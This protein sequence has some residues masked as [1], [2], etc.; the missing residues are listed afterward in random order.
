MT[1]IILLN[2]NGFQDTIECLESLFACTKQD[3]VWAVVDNGS[4][5]E[6][7]Q[8]ITDYLNRRGKD[9]SVVKE[10]E[11]PSFSL[12]AGQGV[13][14]AL[15]ENYGFA[16]GNNM[17][18]ALVERLSDNDG[19]DKP[20]HYLLL[21]NDTLV[22][23]D[24]LEKLET[25]SL[26]NPQY[27]AL[28]PQIRRA[29]N[30]NIIWNCGGKLVF[31]LR[32]YRYENKP[33]SAI[34]E[35]HCMPISLITGCALFV[36]RELIGFPDAW[37]QKKS[38]RYAA[39]PHSQTEATDVLSNRFFFGEEDFDFSLRLQDKKQKMACVLDSVIYH[40]AG[41]SRKQFLPAGH[42]YMH[43]LNRF[44]DVRQHWHPFKFFIWKLIYMP[45]ISLALLLRDKVS[46]REIFRYQKNLWKE[47]A[48]LDGMDKALFLRWIF[49]K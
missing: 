24:F 9:F 16:K 11:N 40:K 38:K 18:I 33:Y 39:R 19:A 26:K 15:G 44:V 8:A 36:K 32:I 2:W 1:A 46:I 25:F 41:E 4:E 6:S 5:N 27:V 30:K 34:K 43:H 21:N 48:E 42:L 12:K 22:E 49:S 13:V 20:A 17:G 14:Y 31:G 37:L 3:F 45:Y 10:G 29:G 7:V 23:P 35:K 47:S 28:T